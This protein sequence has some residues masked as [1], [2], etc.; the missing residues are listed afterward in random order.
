MVHESASEMG[1]VIRAMKGA[2]TPWIPEYRVKVFNGNCIEATDHR[3]EILRKIGSAPLPGKSLVI[4]EPAL[5]R[6]SGL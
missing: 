5:S 2:C 4:Y 1:E 3:L 6:W